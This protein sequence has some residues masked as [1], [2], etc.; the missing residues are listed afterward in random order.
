MIQRNRHPQ[1]AAAL[2]QAKELAEKHD[3]SRCL[4][5][6]KRGAVCGYLSAIGPEAYECGVRG[7][8]ILQEECTGVRWEIVSAGIFEVFGT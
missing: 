2:S 7:E 1:A 8:S 5:L 6:W 4:V 3:S